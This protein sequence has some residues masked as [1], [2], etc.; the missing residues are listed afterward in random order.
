MTKENDKKSKSQDEVAEKFDETKSRED[1]WAL[2]GK[3]VDEK[4]AEEGE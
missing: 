4:A 2:A 1:E 3:K